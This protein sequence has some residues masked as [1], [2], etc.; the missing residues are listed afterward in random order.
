MASVRSLDG[1]CY[2]QPGEPPPLSQMAGSGVVRAQQLIVGRA[3]GV[4]V[5]PGYD[6]ASGGL[7]RKNSW[8]CFSSKTFSVRTAMQSQLQKFSQVLQV[9]T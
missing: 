7:V 9:D 6:L 2:N 4:A 1:L 3:A 5:L 8:L